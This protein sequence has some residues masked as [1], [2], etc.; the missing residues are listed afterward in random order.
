MRVPFDS[1]SLQCVVAEL[2]GFVGGFV[3][4][5][6]QPEDNT[7]TLSIHAPGK[8]GTLLVSTHPEFTRAHL[9]SA[10]TGTINPPP[11]F[12][13]ALRARIVGGRIIAIE[14]VAFDRV[15]RLVVDGRLGQQSLVVE[16]IPNRANMILLDGGN[17]IVTALR[18]MGKGP[19]DVQPGARYQLPKLSDETPG[20]TLSPF[21]RNLLQA[22]EAPLK[23]PVWKS[24]GYFSRG[25]GAYPLSL[26]PLVQEEQTTASLSEALDKHFRE[27]A[28]SYKIEQAR[29]NLLS[30]LTRVMRAR[31]SALSQLDNALQNA[32]SALDWQMRAELILAFGSQLAIGAVSLT[33][34]DYSG[35]S[36]TIAID[37]EKSYIDNAGAL[38]ERAKK[39]KANRVENAEQR[40][41]L[42]IE[43]LELLNMIELA[44]KASQ[45][46]DLDELVVQAEKRRWLNKPNV[47]QSKPEDRPFGGKKVRELLGPGGY[48]VLYGENAEAN[49]YLTLRVAKPNDYWLHVRGGTS[50][51][52]VVQ[53]GKKPDKVP[54]ETLLFAAQVAVRNSPSK[55]SGFV[56]VDC[57]LRKYVRKPHGSPLGTVTYEREKTIHVESK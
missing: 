8:D 13:A 16:L 19:T 23:I 45:L 52:V 24:G 22:Q 10:R 14:Q 54:N 18:R 26:L 31:E 6:R 46:R 49:D 27:A 48:A 39:A 42:N 40:V 9:T 41:R 1:L 51:H 12:C 20:V 38:F 3:Q 5:A 32:K 30:Q 7:I 35:D 17:H 55:H 53:T 29:G 33:T 43:R 36:I 4:D 34:M 57:T 21:L 15:L 25:N 56:P 2:Q 50:A 28:I 47:S 37:P 11:A 44:G